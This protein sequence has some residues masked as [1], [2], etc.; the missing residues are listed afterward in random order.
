MQTATADKDILTYIGYPPLIVHLQPVLN[1]TDDQFYEF[2]QINR[3]LRIERNAQGELII[4]PPTGGE[5]GE[6]NAEITMQLRLWAKRDGTGTT[7][8]SSTGFILPN[9]AVRSPDAAWIK[10]SRLAILTPEQKKKFIPLC[11]DFVIELRSPTDSLSVLQD[12]MEEYLANGVQL[13][14]LIDPEYKRIYIYR[15]QAQME[16]LEEPETLSGDP[17]LA[18]FVLNLRELW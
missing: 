2:C 3:D 17:V 5:T 9:K 16:Q 10:K 4:M 6:R 7:F 18:G 1:M 14:W 11:P 15:S 13:G 12:K 8:D